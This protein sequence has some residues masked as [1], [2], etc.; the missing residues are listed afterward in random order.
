MLRAREFRRASFYT[1]IDLD[2][3]EQATGDEWLRNDCGLEPHC[4]RSGILS[5]YF[6]D[7][8]GEGELLAAGLEAGDFDYGRPARRRKAAWIWLQGQS[9]DVLRDSMREY[10]DLSDDEA[11]IL[12]NMAADRGSL[13][14]RLE[15]GEMSAEHYVEGSGG[16]DLEWR[17]L[18]ASPAEI[19]Q[20]SVILFLWST[21]CRIPVTQTRAPRFRDQVG[22][23]FDAGLDVPVCYCGSYR[24]DQ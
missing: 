3:Y 1:G 18:P 20:Q 2:A 13:F 14:R 19:K 23:E 15:S 9:T 11:E 12:L 22:A 17:T 7:E 8:D 21:N 4:R 10:F 5:L 24:E 6:D 16:E